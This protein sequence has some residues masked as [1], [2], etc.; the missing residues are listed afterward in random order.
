MGINFP[1]SPLVGDLWPNPVVAGQA[2]YTWD[3]EKWTSGGGSGG[4]I[5]DGS[6]YVLK[7]GDIMTGPLVLPADPTVALQAATKQYVDGRPA[8]DSTKVAKAGDTMTGP[9]VIVQGSDNNRSPLTFIKDSGQQVEVVIKTSDGRKRWGYQLADANLETGGNLG[10]NFNLNS[11]K[12]DG[13]FLSGVLQVVRQT[14]EVVLGNLLR[15]PLTLAVGGVSVSSTP[16]DATL[17]R[18][19]ANTTGALF[20]GNSG[21]KY[22]YFD[23]T[24]YQFG[25]VGAS[26]ATPGYQ[27]LPSGLIL[28]WGLTT[29]STNTLG[30]GTINFPV[31]FPNATLNLR[32]SQGDSAAMNII[33][34]TSSTAFNTSAFTVQAAISQTGGPFTSS[35]AKVSWEAIGY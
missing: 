27:K 29:M 6:A 12:D 11:Y 30:Q 34:S 21:A 33:L 22:L 25:G 28:Q 1:A 2:Q 9:L 13:T 24:N 7:A 18:T 8:T 20:L 5:G 14:G 35:S 4:S 15:V 26:F 23:G 10:S 31:T 17:I 3:G 19:G 32:V 16:G